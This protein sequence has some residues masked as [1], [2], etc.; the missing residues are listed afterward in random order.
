LHLLVEAF[1]RPGRSGDGLGA[2]P[3]RA[4]R[5]DVSC[6]RDAA[7]AVWIAIAGRANAT[8]PTYRQLRGGVIRLARALD[9]W[10]VVAALRRDSES[11][12]PRIAEPSPRL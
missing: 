10:P 4:P 6:Y 3:E 12:K 11:L 5:R 7:A 1:T 2:A 8:R 9:H